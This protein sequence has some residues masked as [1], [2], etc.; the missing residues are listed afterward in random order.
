MLLASTPGV[1]LRRQCEILRAALPAIRDGDQEG[2][3]AARI[4]TRRLRELLPLI[5]Y[6]ATGG[7]DL[8]AE[9]K[10]IGRSLGD[11]RDADVQSALMRHLESRIPAAA[12]ALVVV[13]Q[14]R[15]RKRLALVRAL[16]KQLEERDIGKLLDAARIAGRAHLPA[17][18]WSRPAWE[19]RL[20]RA[21]VERAAESRRAIAHATGVYFPNRAH[22]L[23]IALKKFRYAA[24]IA[25]ETAVWAAHDDIRDLKRGQ[26]VLGDLHDRQALID[27][28]TAAVD[29]GSPRIDA[30][31]VNLIVQVVEAEV[32][33]L[34]AKYLAKRGRL[35]E[36]ATRGEAAA[37][38]NLGRAVPVVAGAVAASS[39][40]YALIRRGIDRGSAE[41]E[42]RSS[43]PVATLVTVRRRETV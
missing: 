14:K 12:P 15:E 10:S 7:A 28:L 29:A 5:G 11:V 3:H 37:R 33:D 1:L 25:D 17:W 26:D 36:I 19:Q 38:A 34:H 22:K 23:R 35:A 41:R 4:A 40:L 21:L 32:H 6:P 2:I 9:F 18:S 27:H 39:V 24:E 16:I 30:A 42:E 8:A 31:Q 13:R 20:R 43:S